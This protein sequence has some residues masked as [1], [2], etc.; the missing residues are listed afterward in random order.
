MHFK[1]PYEV[2]PFK[3][4]R[5]LGINFY[6]PALVKHDENSTM[7]VMWLDNNSDSVK[8]NNGQVLT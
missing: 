3:Q 4:T 1:A 8:F 2:H 7:G 6:A 5:F